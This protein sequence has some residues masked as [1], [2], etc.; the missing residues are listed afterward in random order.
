MTVVKTTIQIKSVEDVDEILTKHPEIKL[1][2]TAKSAERLAKHLEDGVKGKLE[3]ASK[4]LLTSTFAWKTPIGVVRVRRNCG[5]GSLGLELSDAAKQE[6]SSLINMLI[7]GKLKRM[8][9][10]ALEENIKKLTTEFFSQV[11][12]D[13]ILKYARDC[14]ARALLDKI[15]KETELKI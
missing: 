15:A 4:A 11:N 12:T 9:D 8:W 10:E 3:A 7:E 14:V 5:E 13:E 1:E 2:L 6:L